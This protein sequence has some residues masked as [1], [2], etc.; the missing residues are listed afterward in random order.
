MDFYKKMLLWQTGIIFLIW[1][2][3]LVVGYVINTLIHEPMWIMTTLTG[4]YIIST[5]CVNTILAI[6]TVYL[7]IDISK[8]D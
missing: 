1:N 6:F 8:Y 2:I 4:D 3:G 5:I 7:W